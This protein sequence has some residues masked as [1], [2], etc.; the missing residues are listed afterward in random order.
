MFGDGSLSFHEFATREPL[1][2]ATV[3]DAVLNFLRGRDD[4]VLDGSQAVNAYVTE[5][6]MTDDVDVLT[7]CPQFIADEIR[8][9]LEREFRIDVR[10]CGLGGRGIDFRVYQQREPRDRRFVDVRHAAPLPEAQR[11]GGVLV[12]RPAEVFARKLVARASRRGAPRSGTD[13]RDLA[14]LILRFPEFKTD[15]REIV[16]A[17][18]ALGATPAVHQD[19]AEFLSQDIRAEKEHEKFL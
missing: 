17:L 15:D 2:L 6:R 18:R 19:L 7:P 5:A 13:L 8:A 1:P 14:V 16:A 4:I 11:V 9:H 3:H 10:V 12:L